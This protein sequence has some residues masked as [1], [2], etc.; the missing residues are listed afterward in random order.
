MVLPFCLVYFWPGI[1]NVVWV[2]VNPGFW[3]LKCF[4][5]ALSCGAWVYCED[6][7]SVLY[8]FFYFLHTISWLSKCQSCHHIETSRLIYSANQ[9]T[10]FYMMAPLTFNE[11]IMFRVKREYRFSEFRYEKKVF[12]LSGLLMFVN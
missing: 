4:L 3:Y 10:G 9:L 5:S 2:W 11:L 7:S 8:I 12:I 6:V 1:L